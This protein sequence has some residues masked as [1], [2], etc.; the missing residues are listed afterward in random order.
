[1]LFWGDLHVHS[2]LGKCG[3]PHLPKHPDF[4]YW[5]ARD[6]FGHDFCSITD[7]ASKL[8][9]ESWEQVKSSAERW[10]TP[11]E[12]VTLLGFEGDY[13]GEDGGH[14]N[15]YFPSDKG[16]YRN[17]KRNA[18]GTLDAVF[19]FAREHKALAICHH[20]SREKCGRDF[21]KSHFGGKE[22]EPAM[23]VFSQWGSSEEY[24]SNRPTIEG[25]HPAPGHYY[26]YALKHGFHLGV[27]GGSDSHCTIPGGP[28]QGR[29]QA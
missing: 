14:F 23:E 12:F 13:D 2:V 29:I 5:Y 19:Q 11:G 1:H 26:R 3:T 18:G 28:V 27:V 10:H 15:L 25:R 16:R 24:A 8:D 7:H 20:T 21:A 6:I 4:G 9:E 17:F 22:I